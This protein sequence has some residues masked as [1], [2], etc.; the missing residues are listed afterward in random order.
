MNTITLP[1]GKCK[2]ALGLSPR[3]DPVA[4]VLFRLCN[5]KKQPPIR[6]RLHMDFCRR[7]VERSI[8]VMDLTF[9][10]TRWLAMKLGGG[11][12]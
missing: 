3:Q 1:T 7:D 10:L 6:N 11:T 4:K 9:F 12:L 8:R 5:T 2:E